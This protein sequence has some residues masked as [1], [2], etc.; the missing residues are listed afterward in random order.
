MLIVGLVH[1]AA[2]PAVCTGVSSTGAQLLASGQDRREKGNFQP[3][4]AVRRKGRSRSDTERERESV[5]HPE[6]GDT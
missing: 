6:H 4:N 1:T 3:P 5:E 2:V